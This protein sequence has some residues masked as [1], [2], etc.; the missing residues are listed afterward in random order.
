MPFVSLLSF[1]DVSPVVCD[2]SGVSC[3]GVSREV[4]CGLGIDLELKVSLQGE[5]QTPFVASI[6]RRLIESAVAFISGVR[7][8]LL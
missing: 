7:P 6:E 5:S 4:R 2:V 3:V 8:T 1:L